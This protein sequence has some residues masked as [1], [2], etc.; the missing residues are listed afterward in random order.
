M[1]SSGEWCWNVRVRSFSRWFGL[2]AFIWTLGSLATGAHAQAKPPVDSKFEK[3][4]WH[5]VDKRS[6]PERALNLA[7]MTLQDVGRSFALITGVYKY[8]KMGEELVPAHID[9][10]KLT[11]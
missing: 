2:L 9:M 11:H 8:P 5:Y 6:L 4:F 7:G 1:A 10:T 3:F